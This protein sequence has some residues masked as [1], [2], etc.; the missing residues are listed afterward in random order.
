MNVAERVVT[1]GERETSVARGARLRALEAA[2]RALHDALASG[3]AEGVSQA[4]AV[5]AALDPV[6]RGGG[7]AVCG[8]ITA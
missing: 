1:L 3:D 5:L 2:Q 8:V 6:G 4:R 7:R